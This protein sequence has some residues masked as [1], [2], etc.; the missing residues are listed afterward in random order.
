MDDAG[1]VYVTDVQARGIGVTSPDGKYRL[2]VQDDKLLD[3]PDG[4]AVDGQ[5]WVYVACSHLYRTMASHADEGKPEPPFALVR[6]KA[7]AGTTQ[8]R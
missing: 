8:G 1:N 2:L 7:L 3:W 5:G 4:I 6:F